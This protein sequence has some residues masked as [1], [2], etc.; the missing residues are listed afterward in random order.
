M[1]WRRQQPEFDSLASL[2]FGDESA[3]QYDALAQAGPVY[4]MGQQAA[5][6]E[7]ISLGEDVIH[8]EQGQ[9]FYVH[10]YSDGSYVPLT[11]AEVNTRL[12]VVGGLPPL[13]QSQTDGST[14]ERK[15]PTEV[16]IETGITFWFNTNG[17]PEY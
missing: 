3:D 4:D 8:T 17:H 11:P 9:S 7:R 12:E 6:S 10:R 2:G 13:E 15:V 14:T 5:P 16:K 1:A